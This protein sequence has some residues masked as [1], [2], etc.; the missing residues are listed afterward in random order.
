MTRLVIEWRTFE[1]PD[2]S[3]IVFAHFPEP[4]PMTDAE[5]AAFASIVL[6]G[7]REEWHGIGEVRRNAR[8][9]SELVAE[10]ENA[11]FVVEQR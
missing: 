9:P 6:E 8:T 2:G 1:E 4:F 7:D 10:L 11:G 5:Y 3:V